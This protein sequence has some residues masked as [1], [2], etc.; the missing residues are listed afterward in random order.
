MGFYLV[1][2]VLPQDKKE[3]HDYFVSELI[4]CPVF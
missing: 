4:H 2:V 1:A 3:I